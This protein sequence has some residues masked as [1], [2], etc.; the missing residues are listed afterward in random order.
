MS[1]YSSHCHCHHIYIL[2]VSHHHQHHQHL[3]IAVVSVNIS[4]NHRELVVWHLTPVWKDV[5]Y[6][7]DDDSQVPTVVLVIWGD[8]YGDLVGDCVVGVGVDLQ[9]LTGFS[10]SPMSCGIVQRLIRPCCDNGLFIRC[11]HRALF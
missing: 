8:V 3:N 4:S 7:L 11:C 5:I 2:L 1:S 10:L 9:V 6:V